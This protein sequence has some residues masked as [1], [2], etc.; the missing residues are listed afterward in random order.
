MR[1]TLS[2]TSSWSHGEMRAQVDDLDLDSPRL[3]RPASA[4]WSDF[5]TVAPHVTMVR[6][7]PGRRTSPDAE[8]DDVVG[9]R[10][11]VDGV[12]LAQ[13]VLVLEEQHRVLA[14]E[15]VAQ[16]P[17][18]VAGPR[19][20]GDE[21]PGDVGEDALAALAVPDGAAGEVAADRHPHHHRAGEGPV[22]APADRGRLALDLGHGRPDV[23]EELDLGRRPQPADRLAD[24]PADDVRLR[25]RRVEA[26][27]L[28]EGP[29]E[30]V[31][32]A[33]HAALA[34]DV[35]QHQPR[36]RRPRPRRTPGCARRPPSARA[37]CA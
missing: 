10:E 20:E 9:G 36:G 15:R 24:G 32:R 21:Q 14:P 23:V 37:A 7:S 16:Q 34:L 4:A 1:A 33:E 19:R 26:A 6:S 11:R 8:R 17:G 25:Q 31:G 18:G 13:Q 3:G 35:G 12:G 22:R 27:G 2:A 5:S 28:P 29:L 30:A